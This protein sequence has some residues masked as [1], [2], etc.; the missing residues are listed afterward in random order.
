MLENS[1]LKRASGA[2]HLTGRLSAF[3]FTSPCRASPKSAT[4]AR[5]NLSSKMFLQGEILFLD[6]LLKT[7]Y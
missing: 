2:V 6:R 7:G 1:C 3:T 4:L 5:L